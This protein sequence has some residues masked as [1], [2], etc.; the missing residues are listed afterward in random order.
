M[1]CRIDYIEEQF[2]ESNPTLADSLNDTFAAVRDKVLESKLFKPANDGTGRYLFAE[3][4]KN[5]T[6]YNAQQEFVST[7]N[8][9]YEAEVIENYNGAVRINVLNLPEAQKELGVSTLAIKQGVDELFQDQSFANQVYEALGF[10][11]PT[12]KLEGKKFDYGEPTFFDI[13]D[14]LASGDR[15][16]L[17]SSILIKKLLNGKFLPTIK[18]SQIILGL[19]EAGIWRPNLKKIEASGENKSTL[20]KKVGHELLHSVTNNIILSYQNLKGVVDFNDKYYKDFIK[21]GYIKPV[22][23]Y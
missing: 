23:L 17:P 12:T 21:Q 19:S 5:I 13:V 1:S 9:S 16:E 10:E 7:T 20:A 18:N 22:N 2:R 4:S 15:S 14:E 3:E 8:K 11:I 6:A